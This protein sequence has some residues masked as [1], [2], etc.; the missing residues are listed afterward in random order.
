MTTMTD[1]SHSIRVQAHRANI[2]RYRKLLAGRLTSV[3]RQYIMRRIA[4]ERA[5]MRRL[6]DASGDT[7]ARLFVES[8]S[9]V[10]GERRAAA[11]RWEQ[12]L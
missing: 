5:E 11:L 7:A 8:E 2:E 12:R 1:L 3:E 9:P 10:E 6:E 4:E